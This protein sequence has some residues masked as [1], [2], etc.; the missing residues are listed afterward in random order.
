MHKKICSYF[1]EETFNYQ[2]SLERVLYAEMNEGMKQA[3]LKDS[4]NRLE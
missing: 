2:S 3:I 4:R 1:E